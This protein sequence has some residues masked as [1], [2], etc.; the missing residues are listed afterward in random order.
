MSTCVGRDIYLNESLKHAPRIISAVDSNPFSPS[1]G[2]CDWRF[3][4][5]KITDIPSGHDQEIVYF[6]ALLYDTKNQRNPY[7]RQ[8]WMLNLIEAV[9]GY[10]C[11]MINRRPALD[12]FY[13]REAQ[14]GATAIVAWAVAESVILLGAAISETTRLETLKALRR[15]GCWLVGNDEETNLANH[16]AQAVLALYLIGALT[17]DPKILLGYSA[18]KLRL[19][20]LFHD[21]S[22]SEEYGFFDPGYQTTCL[23]FLGRLAKLTKC[24]ETEAL[25]VSCHNKLKYF[26]LPS[27]QFGGA[28]GSRKTR[29]IWPSS[30]ELRAASCPVSGAL[31]VHFRRGL[32]MGLVH[33]PSR[34][35]RYAVQ[36]LY[37][38]LYCYRHAPDRVEKKVR[39]PH[40]EAPFFRWFDSS[41][42]IV[43]RTQSGESLVAN[44]KKG[45]TFHYCRTGPSG[46]VLDIVSDSGIA[47]GLAD[48]TTLTSDHNTHDNTIDISSEGPLAITVQGSMRQS[49]FILPSPLKYMAFRICMML[50]GRSDYLRTKIRSAL[51]WLLIVDRRRSSWLYSRTFSVG[52]NQIQV[53]DEVTGPIGSERAVA[54]IAIGC[55]ASSIYVPISKAF[56][57]ETDMACAFMTDRQVAKLETIRTLPKSPRLNSH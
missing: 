55:D 39:L 50:F 11:N 12:E 53:T 33:D 51:A 8:R 17:S 23:S 57:P 37:D 1:F 15:T 49:R 16:Q 6:L 32:S 41:G 18:K 20:R 9:L 46:D 5:D 43:C 7:Y 19:H 4:H 25:I 2:C 56:S 52:L 40:E 30:F 27:Y 21:E 29:H 13:V 47:V 45:G 48:G 42:M 24:A 3:W 35:D 14:Y 38:F 26:F 54:R 31:A 28:T 10:W 36:Q 44:L 34:Q 22:W